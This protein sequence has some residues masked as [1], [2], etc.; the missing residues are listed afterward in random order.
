MTRRRSDT[1]SDRIRG[2]ASDEALR[3]SVFCGGDELPLV[4]MKKM[5]K[6]KGLLY[7]LI[8]FLVM[9]HLS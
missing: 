3:G 5:M 4:W 8:Y 6:T 7:L 2:G 1:G 9:V